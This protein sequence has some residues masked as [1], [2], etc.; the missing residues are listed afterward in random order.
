MYERYNSRERLRGGGEEK[1]EEGEE[2]EEEERHEEERRFVVPRRKDSLALLVRGARKRRVL[3]L[4]KPWNRAHGFVDWPRPFPPVCCVCVRPWRDQCG[5]FRPYLY[6]RTSSTRV[7]YYVARREHM[8]HL[9]IAWYRKR[10]PPLPTAAAAAAD[11]VKHFD[12]GLSLSLLLLHPLYDDRH[13]VYRIWRRE[14]IVFLDRLSFIDI[15]VVRIGLG[16][17]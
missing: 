6:N 3:S 14:I 16:Y 13:P 1:K 17:Y 15:Q 10:E 8:S 12:K 9:H 5:N 2:E 4:Y 11:T 7:I